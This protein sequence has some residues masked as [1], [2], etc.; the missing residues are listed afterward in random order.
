MQKLDSFH[1]DL[2]QNVAAEI[3]K[4]DSHH[5]IVPF[6]KNSYLAGVRIVAR[7][8]DVELFRPELAKPYDNET[9][10]LYHCRICGT[11]VHRPLEKCGRCGAEIGWLSLGGF[12]V[13]EW[14][15]LN[16]QES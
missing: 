12:T 15:N 5:F 13:P 3:K 8:K 2:N 9:V 14:Q 16:L 11:E 10:N 7:S 1:Y 4:V 6:S